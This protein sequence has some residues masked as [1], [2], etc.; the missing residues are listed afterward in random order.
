[1]EPFG[2]EAGLSALAQPRLTKGG[3]PYRPPQGGR[4]QER[5]Y[6]APSRSGGRDVITS[7]PKADART[8]TETGDREACCAE[9]I[10][11]SRVSAVG[12]LVQVFRFG[13]GSRA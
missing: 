10:F 11:R 1:M 5:G 3:Q 7:L 13:Y 6:A 4:G 12:Y 2:F 8:Q 9:C